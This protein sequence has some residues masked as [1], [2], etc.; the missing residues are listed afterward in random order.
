MREKG[1]GQISIFSFLAATMT[2]LS[3]KNDITSRKNEKIE[4]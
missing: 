4:I 3:Y 2:I 1:W